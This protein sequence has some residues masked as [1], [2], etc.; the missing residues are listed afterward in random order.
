[1]YDIEKLIRPPKVPVF[2]TTVWISISDSLG[3]EYA[4]RV[5]A[6]FENPI[7]V[8]FKNDTTEDWNELFISLFLQQKDGLPFYRTRKLGFIVHANDRLSIE[9]SVSNVKG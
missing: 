6:K 4:P 7:S 8:K 1:M 3:D 9:L 5:Q 2:G